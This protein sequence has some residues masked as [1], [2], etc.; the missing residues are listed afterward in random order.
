V[1]RRLNRAFVCTSIIIDDVQKLAEA[2]D[3]LAKHLTSQWEYPLEFIFLTP[4]CRLVSKLNSF[5]DFPGVHSDV[6]APPRTRH[7]GREEES[8]HRD[9]FLRH[10]AAHFGRG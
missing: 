5:K 3:A 2:G 10:L 7:V 8:S 4:D 9:I 6:V 1:I